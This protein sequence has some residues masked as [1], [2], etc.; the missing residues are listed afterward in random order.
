MR[1][2]RSGSFS[3]V[4]LVAVLAVLAGVAAAC[5][6]DDTS[7]T[8]GEP[9]GAS[10][11][12]SQLPEPV[13]PDEVANTDTSGTTIRLV[14]HDSFA[15]SDG[16]LEQFEQETG[17]TVEHL[18]S[19]DTGT[20]VSQTVLTAGD[21]VADVL[22]GIDNTFL[23]RGLQADVFV[24]YESPAL[25]DVPDE[26]ELDPNHLVTPIDVGDVCVNYSKS[27]YPDEVTAPKDLDDL[28][29]PRFANEFVT[30]NPE[31]SSPGFAFLLATI[32][33]YGEDGWEDY[34]TR[35]RDNG[36]MVTNGWEEAYNEAFAGGEGERSIVTSYASSPVVE[37]L[38]ADPPVDTPPTGVVAD[39]CFRQ[40]EFAGILRGTE[41]PEA[42][43][44]LIDFLLSTT[45]QED[46]PL[47][48]FVEPVNEKA[49]LP[50]VF[51]EHR[52]VIDE[53]LMLDPIEIEEGRD[54]W[55]RRWT[56]LVLR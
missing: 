23:C 4:G 10:C 41:H 45:F 21:P 43:A 50:D 20:L 26:L 17:I 49:K 52:T 14:T 38:Y 36:V 42:A 5:G 2:A 32:A 34:W 53:P 35:L 6:D 19:G 40:V 25:A 33:K 13:D 30:E 28:A 1:L 29:D 16:V 46:I 15:V 22:F 24:P 44:K 54:E 55:T 18:E 39:A 9:D 8:T 56:E 7:S 11:A 37:V 48:M 3:F 51:V 27:A 12:P 31:T 47:N